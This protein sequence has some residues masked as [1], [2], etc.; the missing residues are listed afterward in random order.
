MTT[1]LFG[2]YP[3]I[4]LTI[5]I[6]GLILRF[7]YDKF[8]WTSR[9]SQIYESKLLRVG[10]P[11]FHF[12]ILLAILGHAMGLLIPAG[13]TKAVGISEETY[14]SIAIIGGLL[15]GFM[16]VAGFT[17]LL[18]RRLA[19]RAVLRS[20]TT[21]DK[22]MYVV[23]AAVIAT[24]IWNTVSTATGWGLPEGFTYRDN[25]SLWFRS[26]FTLSPQPEFLGGVPIQFQLH[27][28]LAFTFILLI[29]FTRLVHMF[30]VPVGYLI[31]PYIVYRA[32]G[33]PNSARSSNAPKD[34]WKSPTAARQ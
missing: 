12:G 2:V 33:E 8:G 22:F 6:V 19:N 1:F 17:V 28:V 23:L 5:L 14:H 16:V 26:I 10:A 9:S 3:Y 27:A 15:A 11:L 7:R 4:A 29:P 13:W 32:K 25:V 21:A 18:V 24:G 34:T 20:S 30:S 31:R